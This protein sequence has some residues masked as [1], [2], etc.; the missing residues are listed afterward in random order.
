MRVEEMTMNKV[1]WFVLLLLMAISSSGYA[2][3]PKWV[4][5][6]DERGPHY[7]ANNIFFNNNSVGTYLRIVY[8]KLWHSQYGP[9]R[10][11]LF[12]VR[13]SCNSQS[14]ETIR[15]VLYASDDSVLFDGVIQPRVES[16][17]PGS[18]K[19]KA[20]EALCQKRPAWRRALDQVR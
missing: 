1:R 14:V 15:T 6:I 9:V 4:L 8:P 11:A 13:V 2:K 5:L 18:D 12:V 10:T 20:R 7:D 19:D 3:D 16:V 17:L